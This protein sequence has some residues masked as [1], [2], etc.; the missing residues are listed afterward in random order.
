MRMTSPWIMT[1]VVFYAS[2]NIYPR[3]FADL[4]EM[5]L[6]PYEMAK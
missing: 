4:F 1:E 2:R 3:Q 5:A 6:K